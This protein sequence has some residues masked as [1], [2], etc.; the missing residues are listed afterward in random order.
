[1]TVWL[2]NPQRMA[3]EAVAEAF[4]PPPP[5]DYLGWAEENIVF[6]ARESPFPG[7]YNRALFVYF[8]EIL[9]ALGPDDP[10]RT[11]T[12]MKSAQLGGTVL[13]NIFVGGS[14][15]MD[16]GDVLYV[17]PT[18]DNARRWSKMKLTPMIRGTPALR[19]AIPERSRDGSDSVM[20]KEIGRA[21]V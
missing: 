8:D 4:A 15:I 20:Y 13:A 10:C 1:M 21:H 17:H 5:V 18:D 12:L 2:S 16:P 19:S 14:L 7:P 6:S 9:V 11:V 3:S